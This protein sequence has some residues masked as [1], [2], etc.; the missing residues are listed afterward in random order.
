M[1]V[2]IAALLLV[3]H[4][5]LVHSAPVAHSQS[6]VTAIDATN[7][8]A[9]LTGDLSTPT[10]HQHQH[11][12]RDGLTTGFQRF[13]HRGEVEDNEDG[14]EELPSW[15]DEWVNQE[16]NEAT[17]DQALYRHY[18]DYEGEDQEDYEWDNREE[19][20]GI[21]QALYRR[22]HSHGHDHDYEGEGQEEEDEWDSQEEDEW[23]GQ[24]LYRRSYDHGRN[25]GGEDIE[26]QAYRRDH[27]QEEDYSDNDYSGDDDGEWSE[28]DSE[29]EGQN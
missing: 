3:L 8:K 6:T 18:Y 22:D 11:I 5:A 14:G 1:K 28:W 26:Q 23:D 27:D 15:D 9:S 7:P 13:D 16:E 20:S 25:R 10:E 4:T 24:A 17:P 29:D 2:S 12:K 21:G 19:N